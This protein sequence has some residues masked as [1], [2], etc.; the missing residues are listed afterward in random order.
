M[1]HVET[2]LGKMQ[3]WLDRRLGEVRAV[4]GR[5]DSLSAGKV[6]LKR[7]GAVSRD[8]EL[9]ARIPGP[10]LTAGN[11]VLAIPLPG[12]EGK[13][14]KL[15]V[16]GEIQSAVPTSLAYDAPLD[17]LVDSATALQVH[18]SNASNHFWV[19]TVARMVALADSRFVVTYD[20]GFA[21]IA[22]EVARTTGAVTIQGSQSNQFHV[23]NASG[24]DRLR[25]NTAGFIEFGNGGFLR[26][27]SDNY[28]TNP[29]AIDNAT[30]NTR[31]N[32][33]STLG[34]SGGTN[35]QT[36]NGEIFTP[37]NP[38]ITATVG[39][40]AGSGATISVFGGMQGGRIQLT[41]GS[42]ASAQG[43]GSVLLTLTWP[44]ARQSVNYTLILQEA[45]PDA[46]TLS[47]NGRP[48]VDEAGRTTT[49]VA[50]K[51]NAALTN[52]TT[53]VWLYQA[54]SY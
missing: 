49:A 33:N 47:Y 1:G 26:G 3:A 45:D 50:V 4:A 34:V 12:E 18:P 38:S 22:F 41:T 48:W 6:R 25:V 10:K 52:T 30:G 23:A 21:N 46:A 27:W 14:P 15:V 29:W 19:D 17:L 13:P 2:T 32:G 28:V 53:Y 54:V 8:D 31:F 7:L 42:D 11:P 24:L 51:T 43:T 36:L 16:I 5:V 40:G 44:F 35:R 37:S 9:Y 39:V 20:Q